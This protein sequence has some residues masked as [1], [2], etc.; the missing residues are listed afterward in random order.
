MTMIQVSTVRPVSIPVGS[1]A[2][3]A[4]T[5]EVKGGAPIATANRL[6]A[7]LIP[8]FDLSS[9]P[10]KWINFV[11]AALQEI[12]RAQL[13]L[14]WKKESTSLREVNASLF[15]ADALL[16]FASL[17][18][19]GRRLTGDSIKTAIFDFILSIES[20][21][22]EQATKILLSMAAPAKTGSEKACQS[23]A[24]KLETWL[25]GNI[26]AIED[27]QQTILFSVVAK[28]TTRAT[29]LRIQREAYE[30]EGEF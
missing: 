25:E 10:A 6:R 22:R 16:T 23:L 26:D 28:L 30:T 1:V 19:E 14:L 9:L 24:T 12:A 15:T 29:E 18:A 7:I 13:S 4:N 27:S 2:I 8:E 11:S 3:V 5:R 21:R 17:E 20:G